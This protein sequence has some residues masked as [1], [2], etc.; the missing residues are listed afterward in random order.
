MTD[1]DINEMNLFAWG[2]PAPRSKFQFWG[3]YK[4]NPEPVLKVVWAAYESYRVK[5]P[6]AQVYVVRCS[7]WLSYFPSMTER[8]LLNLETVE[9]FPRP[10]FFVP[11]WVSFYQLSPTTGQ[12]FL[13]DGFHQGSPHHASSLQLTRRVKTTRNQGWAGLRM[14]ATPAARYSDNR[15]VPIIATDAELQ[16]YFGDPLFQQI[17]RKTS[18]NQFS[19]VTPRCICGR[20]VAVIG[21]RTICTGCG[22][23]GTL[24]DALAI[25]GQKLEVRHA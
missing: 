10:D 23:K 9:A 6:G 5:H 1:Q 14:Y 20:M 21:Q 13:H 7:A 25:G 24:P 4:D 16:S 12:W 15:R 2:R 8:Q 22:A 11:G 18:T 19:G 17:F 3:S